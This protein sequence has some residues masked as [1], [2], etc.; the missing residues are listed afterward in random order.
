[1]PSGRVILGSGGAAGA[2]RQRYR[3]ARVFSRRGDWPPDV[4]GADLVVNATSERD[5][6]L[7]VSCP[8]VRP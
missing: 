5:A 4:A 8:R 3:E 2:F 7:V 6:V 1:M